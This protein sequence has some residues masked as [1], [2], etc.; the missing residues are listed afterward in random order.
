[1]YIA[2][3]SYAMRVLASFFLSLSHTLIHT[4]THIHTL[5]HSLAHCSSS[6]D[7]RRAR[8]TDQNY[9]YTV[10]YS[11]SECTPAAEKKGE[12]EKKRIE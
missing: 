7:F 5:T 8:I 11:D 10:Q 3:Y 12:E 4:Y 1:M 2:Q 9:S 6:P